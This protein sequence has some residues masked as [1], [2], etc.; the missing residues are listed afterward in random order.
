MYWGKS[1]S[2]FFSLAVK[3]LFPVPPGT[4]LSGIPPSSLYCTQKSLSRISAAAANLRRAASP[5]VRPPLSASRS[6]PRRVSSPVPTAA[7]P[8]AVSPLLMNERRLIELFSLFSRSFI[9]HL[10]KAKSLITSD[11]AIVSGTQKKC[12][13]FLRFQKLNDDHI[14]R[15]R[16]STVRSDTRLDKVLP[17]TRVP[18]G[19]S[20]RKVL[21]QT[22]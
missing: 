9:T 13:L 12:H 16:T 11:R 20:F 8:A 10:L 4:S 3:N 1:E 18:I 6:S 7:V 14:D 15:D 21:S 5:G 19:T 17:Y 2:R 22:R